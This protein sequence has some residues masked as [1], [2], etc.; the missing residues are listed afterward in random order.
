MTPTRADLERL[1]ET[2]RKEAELLRKFAE[3]LP[4]YQAMDLWRLALDYEGRANELAALLTSE[5]PAQTKCADCG[6]DGYYK[7]PR[8]G[9]E[10]C[11]TCKGTGEPAQQPET[12]P[13]CGEAWDRFNIHVTCGLPY[14]HAENHRGEHQGV[15]VQWPNDEPLPV[16]VTRPHR[17]KLLTS[18]G[19]TIDHYPPAQQPETPQESP[20]EE[21]SAPRVER[22]ELLGGLAIAIVPVPF[23]DHYVNHEARLVGAGVRPGGVPLGMASSRNGVVEGLALELERLVDELQRP[24]TP[25]DLGVRCPC[26]RNINPPSAMVGDRCKFCVAEGET[27][28][29]TPPVSGTRCPCGAAHHFPATCPCVCHE[30]PQPQ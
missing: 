10:P 5:G 27:P 9:D 7:G 24:E 21:L 11:P 17:D 13:A 22:F 3:S 8:L 29:D 28:A 15:S 14:G 30:P 19:I 1:I 2:W 26:C 18:D 20:V 6:G 12:P 16:T 23:G 25:A 4:H